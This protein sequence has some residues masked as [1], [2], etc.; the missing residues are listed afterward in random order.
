MFPGAGFTWDAKTNMWVPPRNPAKATSAS[1]AYARSKTQCLQRFP[2]IAPWD[3]P[4]SFP[5]AD[6]A[7][8]SG[9]VLQKLMHRVLEIISMTHASCA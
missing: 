6:T 5:A 9:Q 2:D 1:F 4:E 3:T 8:R 7:Y